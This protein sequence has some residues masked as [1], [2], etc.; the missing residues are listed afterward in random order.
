[1]VSE[2]FSPYSYYLNYE[3]ILCPNPNP[4]TLEPMRELDLP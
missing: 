2:V 1:M 4:K 3:R